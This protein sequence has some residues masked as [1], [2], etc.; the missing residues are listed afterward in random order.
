MEC[1]GANFPNNAVKVFDLTDP[2]ISYRLEFTRNLLPGEIYACFLQVNDRF[3]KD[4]LLTIR[5]SSRQ[6]CSSSYRGNS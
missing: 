5:V 4:S 1:Q 3:S 6:I 2:I